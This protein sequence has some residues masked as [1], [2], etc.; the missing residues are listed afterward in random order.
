MAVRRPVN[1]GDIET[2][3]NYTQKTIGRIYF[4]WL[5]GIVVGAT[6]FKPSSVNFGG[7]SFNMENPEIIEGVLFLGCICFYIAMCMPGIRVAGLPPYTTLRLRTAIYANI[8]FRDKSLT[9]RSGAE[10]KY[11]KLRAKGFRCYVRFASVVYYGLPLFHILVFRY[12]AVWTALKL[13]I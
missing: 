8:P 6:G 9:K 5:I 3:Y 12:H 13:I 11:I 1:V 7:V 4:L 10:R 2:V